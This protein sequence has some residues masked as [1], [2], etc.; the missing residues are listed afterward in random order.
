MFGAEVGTWHNWSDYPL[1]PMKERG[2][3]LYKDAD[4]TIFI[5]FEHPGK[6][7]PIESLLPENGRNSGFDDFRI[8]DY[9]DLAYLVLAAPDDWNEFGQNTNVKGATKENPTKVS[10]PAPNLDFL[11]LRTETGDMDVDR[12]SELFKIVAAF[13]AAP[14]NELALEPGLVA[15]LWRSG[16]KPDA[17]INYI[18][19]ITDT[20]GKSTIPTGRGFEAMNTVV[21]TFKSVKNLGPNDVLS[22]DVVR[23][24]MAR[25]LRATRSVNVPSP[26][27]SNPV[28][29][30]SDYKRLGLVGADGGAELSNVRRMARQVFAPSKSPSFNELVGFADQ[31]ISQSVKKDS[32]PNKA[33][34]AMLKKKRVQGKLNRKRGRR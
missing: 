26:E 23:D 13:W 2:R 32:G 11:N 12:A 16:M 27:A 14:Q 19:G 30:W 20:K 21:E 8:T 3:F 9:F 6:G 25:W 28:L 4:G 15:T 18:R 24:F 7:V 10:P 29:H 34:K 22:Q 31:Q 17:I 5:K 1:V 33:V